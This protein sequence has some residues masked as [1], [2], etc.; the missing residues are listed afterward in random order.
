MGKNVRFELNLQGLNELMKS[1]E[2]CH[3]LEQA[4]EE[5]ARAAGGDYGVRV[6]TAKRV[7]IANVYPN[8]KEAAKDNYEHNT[9]L[10]AVE[11]SG[12][13][14]SKRKTRRSIKDMSQEEI[15]RIRK[16]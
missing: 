4:G 11:S 13:S 6:H 8:S 3:A 5:V 9:L 10:K 7:A 14:M 2:M 15:N 12:L 1:E 16:R